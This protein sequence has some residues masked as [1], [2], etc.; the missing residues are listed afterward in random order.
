LFFNVSFSSV[1]TL[2]LFILLLAGPSRAIRKGRSSPSTG[3]S[4]GTMRKLGAESRRP[5]R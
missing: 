4:E 1:A 3:T 5:A 2:L